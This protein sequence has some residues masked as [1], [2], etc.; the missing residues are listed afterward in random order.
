MLLETSDGI[1]CDICKSQQKLDFTYYSLDFRK[2]TMPPG[3]KPYIHSTVINDI[4]MCQGCFD[5][6]AAVIVKN[7]KAAANGINCDF[8]GQELSGDFIFMKVS[9]IAVS[10]E[11]IKAKCNKCEREFDFNRESESACSCGSN[12][13]S[14]ALNTQVDNN[15]L[16]VYICNNEADI[17]INKKEKDD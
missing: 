15:F 4:D 1:K 5:N 3:A 10:S 8:T 17:L 6:M 14:I 13:L 9:K 7:Y 16:E 11:G 2:C 12:D